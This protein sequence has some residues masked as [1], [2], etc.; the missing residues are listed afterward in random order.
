MSDLGL[1]CLPMSLY[2]TFGG[3]SAQVTYLHTFVTILCK[4]SGF[5]IEKQAITRSA[6]VY[7]TGRTLS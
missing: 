4:D 3:H 7:E 6:S 1:H 2:G 5:P